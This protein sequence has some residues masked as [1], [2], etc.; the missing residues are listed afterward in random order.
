M[1]LP[2]EHRAGGEA[3]IIR[4]PDRPPRERSGNEVIEPGIDVSQNAGQPIEAAALSRA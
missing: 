2:A 4:N 1:T 3:A